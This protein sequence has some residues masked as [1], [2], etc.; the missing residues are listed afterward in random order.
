MSEAPNL[1]VGLIERSLHVS[2]GLQPM[3]DTR[4]HV[5]AGG[6]QPM[7]PPFNDVEPCRCVVWWLCE[8][9]DRP[10]LSMNESI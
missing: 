4:L 8:V 6:L 7:R 5:N 3:N 2:V 9:K 10:W 1:F